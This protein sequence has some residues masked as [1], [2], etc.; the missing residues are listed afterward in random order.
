MYQALYRKYRPVTFDDVI[1]QAHITTTLK[2]QILTGK[3]AHAYLFTG[4]RG[5]GK[6]TC[7]RIFAKALN[8]ENPKDGSPCNECSV[9][10]EADDFALSDI[11]E[12]DAASNNSVNDAR[13]LREAAVY[14]PERCKYKVYIIDEVHMLSKE[15]FNALLKIIEEPPPHIKFIMATTELHKVLPTILS[16][17][18]RFDFAR[19]RTEDI[20][21]RIEEIAKKEEI[22]IDREA[23]ELIAKTADGGMRDALSILDRCIAFSENITAEI[24]SEAAG[25]A[26]RESIFELARA[27]VDKD[28][29]K[30][31]EIIA[32]LYDRSKDMSRLC[33]E[34]ITQFRNILVTVS[35]PSLTGIIVCMPSELA[36]IKEIA[37]KVDTAAVIAYLDD[38][39]K[40][41]E[42]M[43][44]S[45]SKRVDMEMCVIRMCSGIPA[46]QT[47]ANNASGK[48]EE[49]A[50]L[51]ARIAALEDALRRG[52]VAMPSRSEP[53]GTSYPE[54]GAAGAPQPPGRER[55]E[56][57][58]TADISSFEYVREWQD[59]IDRLRETCP[60]IAPMLIG[61][62]GYVKSGKF[63]INTQKPMI[64][65]IMSADENKT[66][67]L[68]AIAEITGKAYATVM[69]GY[70]PELDRHF[71]GEETSSPASDDTGKTGGDLNALLQK[72]RDGGVEVT[73]T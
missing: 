42:K 16:R 50:R 26:G 41:A 40:C 28:A 65:K 27:I 32:G 67:V 30:A 68:E 47:A 34:L 21:D 48:S 29:P 13:E 72:A 54:P 36:V 33:E 11:I 22:V 70:K 31:L 2:N 52:A 39:G 62:N 69:V 35:A 18:Q 15:A 17:C 1:S 46:G 9:C 73:E 57:A 44:R 49:I 37:E 55:Q 60:S 7:A 59:I 4:S 19:I 23:A 3:T 25:I 8:C 12:I 38:L 43:T 24:V 5:T 6:T 66:K 63:I 53:R 51:N 45:L 61:S 56:A 64:R 58:P 14:T 10:R 71:G 20:A